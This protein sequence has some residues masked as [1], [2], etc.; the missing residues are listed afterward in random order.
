MKNVQ[1]SGEAGFAEQEAEEKKVKSS[2][3]FYTEKGFLGRASLQLNETDLF[4]KD[5]GKQIYT[6]K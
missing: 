6:C 1:L 2:A 4:V 3:K 5:V